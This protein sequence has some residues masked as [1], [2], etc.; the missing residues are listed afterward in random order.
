MLASDALILQYYEEPDPG[1]AAFGHDLS[2]KDLTPAPKGYEPV[3]VSHYGRHGS[4]LSE[5]AHRPF[6][7]LLVY[8]PKRK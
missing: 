7:Q 8:L 3:Y 4:R 2:P 1:K 5:G 6:R